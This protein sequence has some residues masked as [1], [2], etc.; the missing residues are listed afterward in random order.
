MRINEE[1]Q[2]ETT[3]ANKGTSC[4][5][6]WRGWLDVNRDGGETRKGKITIKI[7]GKSGKCC[8]SSPTGKAA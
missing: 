2:Y 1:W 7:S 4:H 8:G 6:G 3:K 5:A